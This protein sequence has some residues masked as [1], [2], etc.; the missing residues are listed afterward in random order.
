MIKS[1]DSYVSIAS[2]R[3]MFWTNLMQTLINAGQ[4]QYILHTHARTHARTHA[5]KVG[6]MPMPWQFLSNVD[7][8]Y[9]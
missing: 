3:A 5:H 8:F 7:N 9:V 4:Q 6:G 1:L 2:D